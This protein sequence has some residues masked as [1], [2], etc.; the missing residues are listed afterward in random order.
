MDGDNARMFCLGAAQDAVYQAD[1]Q[2]HPHQ[3]GLEQQ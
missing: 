1:E 2:Q 3:D